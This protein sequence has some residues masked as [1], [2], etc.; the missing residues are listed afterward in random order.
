MNL[1][2]TLSNINKK[3]IA[4]IDNNPVLTEDNL[5]YVTD[6]INYKY[7]SK[8]SVVNVILEHEMQNRNLQVYNYK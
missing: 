6:Y 8:T 1:P 2:E 3:L 5:K 7:F 4:M